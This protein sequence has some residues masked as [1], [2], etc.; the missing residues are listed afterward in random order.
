MP[1]EQ[2]S[3]AE[4][5]GA[6][7]KDRQNTRTVGPQQPRVSRKSNGAEGEA[8]PF[9]DE[10]VPMETIEATNPEIEGLEADA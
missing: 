9:S 8:W 7:E 5:V 6:F 2:M 3:L 10:R 4:G 1:P